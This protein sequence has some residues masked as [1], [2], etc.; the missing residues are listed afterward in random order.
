MM[1]GPY[2]RVAQEFAAA[3]YTFNTSDQLALIDGSMFMTQR[4]AL[5]VVGGA[6][7]KR[8]CDGHR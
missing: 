7:A 3:N 1:R 2:Q 6:R 5:G 4:Y 8:F